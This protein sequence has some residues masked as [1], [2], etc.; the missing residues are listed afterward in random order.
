M[1][2]RTVLKSLMAPLVVP[3]GIFANSQPQTTITMDSYHARAVGGSWVE[4]DAVETKKVKFIEHWV[5]GC[6]IGTTKLPLDRVIL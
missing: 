5:N 1:K 2:R 4:L 6:Y 3:L